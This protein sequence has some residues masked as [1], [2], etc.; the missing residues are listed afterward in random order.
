MVER[1]EAVGCFARWDR[2]AGRN[3]IAVARYSI[4]TLNRRRT[5]TTT[6]RGIERGGWGLSVKLP[7]RAAITPK[8]LRSLFPKYIKVLLPNSYS[9]FALLPHTLINDKFDRG[10]VCLLAVSSAQSVSA[11]GIPML[12][13]FSTS[14][15]SLSL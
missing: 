5:C 7:L 11:F 3:N 15:S 9:M 12:S 13:H 4:Q 14:F 2:C 1:G 6:A 10:V 8:H